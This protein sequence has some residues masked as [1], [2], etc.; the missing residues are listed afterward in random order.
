[1]VPELLWT[2]ERTGSFGWVRSGKDHALVARVDAA[3]WFI[4]PDGEAADQPIGAGIQT[5]KEGE[6]MAYLA[7]RARDLVR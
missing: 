4:W 1:M 5:G 2:R 3:G 6:R 7:L